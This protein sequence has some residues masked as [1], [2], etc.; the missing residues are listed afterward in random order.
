M[1]LPTLH[2]PDTAEEEVSSDLRRCRRRA[3]S[4]ASRES[5]GSLMAR[6]SRGG[7]LIPRHQQV[8]STNHFFSGVRIPDPESMEPL[9]MKFPNISYSALALMKGCL[10]MDPAERQSCEQL[11]QHPYFDSFREAAELG[12]EREKSPRKPARLTR[13]HVPGPQHLPQLTCSN[14]LPALDSKKNCCKTRKSKYHF[15]HI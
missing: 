8:F 2:Q 15:P 6:M 9:E 7:D 10:R 4:H 1:P 12:R 14:T 5:L 11:L 3:G 13:K